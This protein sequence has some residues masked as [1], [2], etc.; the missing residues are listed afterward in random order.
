MEA[1]AEILIGSSEK[2]LEWHYPIIGQSIAPSSFFRPFVFAC[3]ARD[4][5]DKKITCELIGVPPSLDT[6]QHMEEFI[7]EWEDIPLEQQKQF[8]Q[9]ALQRAFQI[10]VPILVNTINDPEKLVVQFNVRFEPLRPYRG[11]IFF[12]LKKKNGHGGKWRFEIVLDVTDPPI[13]DVI[14][15]ESSLNQTSSVSFNL[16]NQFREKAF[17]KAEFSAGSSSAFT[18]HPSEGILPPYGSEDAIHFLVSFT[19]TGYGKMQ[20]GQLIILTDEMQWTFNVKGTYPDYKSSGTNSSSKG[21][22]LALSSPS[23]P[24]VSIV[25]APLSSSF[26][27]PKSPSLLKIKNKNITKRNNK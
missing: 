16:R 14:T 9:I 20:S 8:P 2:G 11:S 21:R 7:F 13:D 12:H 18:A 22:L 4:V 6:P 24:T 25:G 15:I 10:S 5:C 1:T 19:P 26:H 3:Q 23:S 17:F 27:S